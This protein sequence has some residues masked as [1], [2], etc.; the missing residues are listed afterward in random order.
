VAEL[1]RRHAEII[2]TIKTQVPS[3][4]CEI[5]LGLGDEMVGDIS[6]KWSR[7]VVSCE[8]NLYG[9][10]YDAEQV[11]ICLGEAKVFL[12]EPY[13]LS[14]SIPYYNPHVYS[15][16]EELLTPFFINQQSQEDHH[17]DQEIDN[18]LYQTHHDESWSR[19]ELDRRIKSPLQP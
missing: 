15:T 17:F 9:P 8:M 1:D 16:T 5:L 2:K 13:F 18:I 4:R 3:L 10:A 14:P 12:Q 7:M 6:K 19:F 11:G